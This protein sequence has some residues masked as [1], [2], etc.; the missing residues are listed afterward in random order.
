MRKEMR[1]GA[2]GGGARGEG[3]QGGARK[4]ARWVKRG[5][6]SVARAWRHAGGMKKSPPGCCPSSSALPSSFFRQFLV[7]LRPFISSRAGRRASNAPLAFFPLPHLTVHLYH[8]ARPSLSRTRRLA[9]AFALLL[10]SRS[11]SHH[12]SLRS[13]R[14]PPFAFRTLFSP[15]LSFTP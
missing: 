6:G 14:T 11:L 7:F 10:L 9:F 12:A 2:R 1:R 13:P 5:K 8:A 15:F 3:G 4:G